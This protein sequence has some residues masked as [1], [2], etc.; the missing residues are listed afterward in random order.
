MMTATVVICA[1]SKLVIWP[2]SS[3]MKADTTVA[4][5]KN[6]ITPMPSVTI[7]TRL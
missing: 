2:I 3:T 5:S 6:L 4:T 7:M 1:E